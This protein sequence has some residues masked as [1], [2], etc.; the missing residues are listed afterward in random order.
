[1]KKIAIIATFTFITIIGFGWSYFSANPL[2]ILAL[3][4]LFCSF[5]AARMMSCSTRWNF[6]AHLL[7]TAANISLITLFA[8]S[9]E[10]I[11]VLQPLAFSFTSVQ[12]CFTYWPR[13]D[14]SVPA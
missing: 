2:Q 9:G 14:T 3:A 10:W 8:L 7:Y 12:G 11:L 4:A 6:E 1:M 13:K 5:P